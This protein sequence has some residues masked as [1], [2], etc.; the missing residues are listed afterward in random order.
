MGRPRGRAGLHDRDVS[1]L[2]R[3]KRAVVAW[4]ASHAGNL[5]DQFDTCVI[6]LAKDR[7]AA[8]QAI[9]GNFGNEELR[10]VRVGTGVG[11]GKAAGAIELQVG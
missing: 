9:V 2:N 10:A 5:L 11:I 7:V 1:N 4:V 8:V 6:A 3:T